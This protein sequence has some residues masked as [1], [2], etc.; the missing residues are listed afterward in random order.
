VHVRSISS[1]L[2][3]LA[4][5][6]VTLAACGSGVAAKAVYVDVATETIHVGDP[7]PAPT[8]DVVLTVSGDIAKAN[9]GSTV[10]L[11]LATVE[12]MGLVKYTVLD[13]WLDAS[14]EFTGVLL[15]DFLDTIGVSA[16][17]A[18]LHFVAIDDYEVEISVADVRKWPVLLATKMDGQ[19]MSIADKGPMRVV[20]PYDQY[21]EIDRLAYKDLWIWSLES[22]EVR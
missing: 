17:S 12:Q 22:L 5:V 4:L 15:S 3:P 14:H 21:P 6:L 11:D 2:A 10:R 1:G 16:A 18:H 8:G 9:A 20:F 13:P 19:P 7:I